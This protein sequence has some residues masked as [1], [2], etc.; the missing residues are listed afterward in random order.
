MLMNGREASFDLHELIALTF[1]K[2]GTPAE[3]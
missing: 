2:T 3:F 1:M